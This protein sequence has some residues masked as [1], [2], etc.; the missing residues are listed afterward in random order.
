MAKVKQLT[1][2]LE[3]RPGTL[4]H[5]AKVLA[6]A[7]VKYEGEMTIRVFR[8][9]SEICALIGP[10][11][12]EGDAGFGDTPSAALRALADVLEHAGAVNER[13][14]DAA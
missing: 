3:N 7:K 14:N 9:G 8:D 2:A 4:A 5:A 10:D 11:L 13:R 12:M 1:V 6:D